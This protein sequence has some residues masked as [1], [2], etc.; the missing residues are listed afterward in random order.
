MLFQIT[1][2]YGTVTQRY[3]VL[4][5]E[6]ADA[7]EALREG[8]RALPEEIVGQV[9]LMEIRLAVDPDRRGYLEEGSR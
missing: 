4:Q 2:R 6:A 7:R 9:D 3:H 1:V 8:A 5:V